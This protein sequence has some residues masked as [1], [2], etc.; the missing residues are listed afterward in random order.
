MDEL[1]EIKRRYDLLKPFLNEKARRLFLAAEA[2]V[3]GRGG[4]EKVSKNTG[5][6]S[7]TISKGCKELVEKPEIIES[8]KIRK[9]GGGRKKL[10][11][12]D[13]TLLSDL[14]SLIEPTTR[15]DPESPLR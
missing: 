1:S 2:G 7:D 4:I 14:D 3:I 8:G 15:G 5:V 13:L 10:I 9:P 12:T 11:D 6:S